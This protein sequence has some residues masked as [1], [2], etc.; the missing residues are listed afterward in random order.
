MRSHTH[1]HRV[2]KPLSLHGK[3]STPP[4]A[5]YTVL[6]LAYVAALCHVREELQERYGGKLTHH[7]SGVLYE[8]FSKIMR[9]LV[10]KKITVPGSF[11][12]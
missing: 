5:V 4:C 2:S 7:M 1:P 10:G 12:K 11:K 3:R 9:A 6:T 8:V